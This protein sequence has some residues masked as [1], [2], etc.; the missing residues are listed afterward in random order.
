MSPI[1]DQQ[2]EQLKVAAGNL[3][4]RV[5]GS[6]G[7]FRRSLLF[8]AVL[9]ALLGLC[10][11]F[12]PVTSMQLLVQMVGVFC[13]IDGAASIVNGSKAEAGQQ[14]WG[15]AIVSLLIGAVLLI[16]PGSTKVLL[17]LFGAWMLYTGIRHI[18]FSRSLPAGDQERS[19]VFA[20]GIIA[21]VVGL[22]LLL[23]PK[24]GVTTLAWVIGIAALLVA[25]LLAYVASRL[26]RAGTRVG[27]IGH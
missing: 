5:A 14:Y 7:D 10:V 1:D 27:N 15:E 19:A 9:L 24:V 23:W 20:I 26:Q 18:L 21:T 12:W 8:K 2:R 17:V 6:L 16:W 13:V 4:I 3:Q 22:V 11:L 25:G